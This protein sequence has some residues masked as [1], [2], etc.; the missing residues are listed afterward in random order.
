MSAAQA[1]FK[2]GR[3]ETC[4]RLKTVEMPKTAEDIE[5]QI[6]QLQK[7]QAALK[8]K[9]GKEASKKVKAAAAE[10]RESALDESCGEGAEEK[11]PSAGKFTTAFVVGRHKP[12]SNLSL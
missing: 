12:R 10:Q 4:T 2:F 5:K 9:E 6:K 11:K 3:E 1:S 8:G 7:E